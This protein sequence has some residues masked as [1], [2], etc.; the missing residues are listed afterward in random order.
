MRKLNHGWIRLASC[1]ILALGAG[2]V[3]SACGGGKSSP[4]ASNGGGGG[5][6]GAA[7]VSGKAIANSI[8]GATVTVF[9]VKP[10]GSDDQTLCSGTTGADG[11]FSISGCK[12]PASGANCSSSSRRASFR[13]NCRSTDRPCESIEGRLCRPLSF[14]AG[15]RSRLKWRSEQ[16][17]QYLPR[18]P[19]GSRQDDHRPATCQA[20]WLAVS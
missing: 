18:W 11:S 15:S 20:A 10:D 16:L 19:D 5:G 7:T 17:Q 3:L 8:A 9:S 12:T 13:T 4:A 14:V 6:G 2:I 1:G